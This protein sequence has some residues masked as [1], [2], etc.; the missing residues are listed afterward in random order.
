[1][2]KPIPLDAY[3][4]TGLVAEE[5]VNALR[6]MHQ[7]EVMVTESDYTA[8]TQYRCWTRQQLVNPVY[9]P[10]WT[11]NLGQYRATV[12]EAAEDLLGRLVARAQG[13][14]S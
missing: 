11:R 12:Q 1:M 7:G 13:R 4:V 2:S 9:G 8:S 5:T 10:Q 14:A 3:V 6:A